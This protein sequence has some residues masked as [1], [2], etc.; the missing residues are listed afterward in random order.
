MSALRCRSSSRSG[1]ID[2]STAMRASSCRNVTA[3]GPA[4][5]MPDATQSSTRA[6]VSA[7]SASSSHSSACGGTIATA[8][9]SVRA[10][11][12]SRAARASTASRT[13]G[14]MSSAAAASTSLT[15]NG[16]PAVLA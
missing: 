1:V 11:G 14:G 13:V 3:P 9:S 15:K 7:A 10:S 6:N 5:S 4:I 12:L 16:L 2:A 8:S